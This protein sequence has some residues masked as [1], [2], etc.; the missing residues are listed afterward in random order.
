MYSGSDV[1]KSKNE[2]F[3]KNVFEKYKIPYKY[4]TAL[5][6]N[7]PSGYVPDYLLSFYEIDRCIYAEICGMSDDY[8]YS[9][10]TAKKINFYSVNRY[11]P[12]REIVYA[13]MYDKYNFDENYFVA[14]VLGAYEAMIPEDALDWK[15]VQPP[16]VVKD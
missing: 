9:A 13:F 4:E 6:V 8:E 14:V 5:T 10:G 7:N 16:Q 1:L 15:N 12:G 3:G 2:Q 11:R